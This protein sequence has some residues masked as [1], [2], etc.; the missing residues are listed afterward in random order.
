[1]SRPVTTKT[2]AWRRTV[3]GLALAALTLS[4]GP[5]WGQWNYVDRNAYTPMG[6][7]LDIA[8]VR[9]E[10]ERRMTMNPRNE[11]A[12]WNT[13]YDF[14]R[15][16]PKNQDTA[17]AIK[18]GFLRARADTPEQREILRK[19]AIYWEKIHDYGI[20]NVPVANDPNTRDMIYYGSTAKH[21]T[22]IMSRP[23]AKHRPHRDFRNFDWPGRTLEKR[24]PYKGR[25]DNP[26]P[27]KYYPGMYPP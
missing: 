24:A 7:E 17:N 22:L 23:G 12:L 25:P 3:L 11:A 20:G 27:G 10:L 19:A 18:E 21:S 8:T 26:Y 5:A 15:N 6:Q 4:S 9:D 14:F 1:M 2:P 16:F 13:G